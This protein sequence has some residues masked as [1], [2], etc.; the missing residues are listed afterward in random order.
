MATNTALALAA[1]L[2]PQLDVGAFHV[3]KSFAI[4]A[5]V[6]ANGDL[7]KLMTFGR[8]GTIVK[9]DAALSA[10]LGANATM[11]FAVGDGTT[12]VDL[13]SA[14]TAGAASKV[15]GNTIGPID[16]AAGAS[17]YAIIGG[18]DVSAAATLKVNLLQSLS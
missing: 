6:G 15:N 13:T 16:Y 1:V 8:A 14:T 2:Q 7:V 18:A 4:P 12:N 17:L 11:K 9:F 10:T 5:T 3:Q